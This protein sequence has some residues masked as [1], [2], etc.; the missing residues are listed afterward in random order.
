T[1]MNGT[2]GKTASTQNIPNATH[3]STTL[4]VQI[5]E[6]VQNNLSPQ[7][8]VHNLRSG[9]GYVHNLLAQLKL[10]NLQKLEQTNKQR[11]QVNSKSVKIRE[12][13]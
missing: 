1:G 4:E 11:L 13:R 6:T 8:Y 10:K 3:P 9:S 5:E 2:V 12:R 7:N